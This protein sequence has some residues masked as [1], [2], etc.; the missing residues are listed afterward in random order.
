MFSNPFLLLSTVVK[1]IA[2]ISNDLLFIE[3]MNSRII[4]PFDIAHILHIYDTIPL[5]LYKLLAKTLY[6]EQCSM[7]Y[8]YLD[9]LNHHVPLLKLSFVIHYT[10]H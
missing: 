1:S 2:N 9:A 6:L 7:F 4:I 5:R 3:P 10:S 8:Q